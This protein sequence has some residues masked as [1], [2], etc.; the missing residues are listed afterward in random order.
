MLCCVVYRTN[1]SSMTIRRDTAREP[2]AMNMRESDRQVNKR[3][4]DKFII[5]NG[6]SEIRWQFVFLQFFTSS[7]CYDVQVF[8]VCVPAKLFMHINFQ[9]FLA[10]AI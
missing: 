10:S 9:A 1:S 2:V 7:C 5:L 3:G 8:F 4:P 6:S